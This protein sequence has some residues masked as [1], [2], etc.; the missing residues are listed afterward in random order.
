MDGVAESVG[1]TGLL[2]ERARVQPVVSWFSLTAEIST[3]F[4][5]YF[6]YYSAQ[7]CLLHFLD[8]FLHLMVAGN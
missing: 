8:S 3:S 5:R 6:A 1:K 7:K 2:R 4:Q